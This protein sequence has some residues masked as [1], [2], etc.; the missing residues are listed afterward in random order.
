MRGWLHNLQQ[1][2]RYL[3]DRPKE[4]RPK[5]LLL[6]W[7]HVLPSQNGNKS[8]RVFVVGFL[9]LQF[10]AAFLFWFLFFNVPREVACMYG[11]VV[12]FGSECF[13]SLRRAEEKRATHE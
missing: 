6:R 13:R 8:K 1:P 5:I 12:I 2:G 11:L 3:D 9:A 10:A 7:L 4:G